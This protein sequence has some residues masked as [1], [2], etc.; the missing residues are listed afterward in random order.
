MRNPASPRRGDLY[1]LDWTPA[2]GSEQAGRRPG[3][4]VS[5]DMGNRF[6]PVVTVVAVTARPPRREYPVNV[7]V[8][9]SVATG[10]TRDSTVLC[11]QLMTVSK[12]RLGQYV[13]TLPPD[14]MRQVDD[15]L[16][17]ALDLT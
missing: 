13:G 14:L 8:P 17:V 11:S 3:L 12:D 5:N 16:R 15:A 4:V 6:A 7:H 9:T 10:L 1:V 2:R